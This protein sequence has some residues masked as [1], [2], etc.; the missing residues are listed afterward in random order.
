MFGRVENVANDE[1]FDHHDALGDRTFRVTKFEGG[2][3]WNTAL[4]GPL[5]LALGGSLAAYAKPS[6][7]DA[8]NGDDPIQWTL[9]AKL[10]VGH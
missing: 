1:L 9:F 10:S 4:V 5:N 8:A 3:A 2:Y 7:L 6:V